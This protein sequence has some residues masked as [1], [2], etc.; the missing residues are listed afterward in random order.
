MKQLIIL[1]VVLTL[2]S[3]LSYGQEVDESQVQV[4]QSFLNFVLKGENEKG[5]L[6]FDKTNVPEINKEQ[7]DNAV[8]QMKTDL[9]LF[10]HLN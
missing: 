2:S 3:N 5:W 8:N 1:I 10:T 9:S 6:L 4:G 7:F